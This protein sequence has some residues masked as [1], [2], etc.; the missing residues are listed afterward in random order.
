[1]EQFLTNVA[2][3]LVGV[4]V[5]LELQHPARREEPGGQNQREEVERRLA[6]RL[7]YFGARDGAQDGRQKAGRPRRHQQQQ[8][9]HLHAQGHEDR[10]HQGVH[11]CLKQSIQPPDGA[12]VYRSSSIVAPAFGS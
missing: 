6:H 4:V 7:Q 10:H 11:R 2:A 12:A 3:L 5:T 9:G 1:V 8:G